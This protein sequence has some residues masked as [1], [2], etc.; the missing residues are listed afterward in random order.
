MEIDLNE[1]PQEMIFN[2]WGIQG[3]N[4]LVNGDFLD[5]NELLQEAD[6]EAIQ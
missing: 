4:F 1:Y 6:E 5:L 2:P 3:Q